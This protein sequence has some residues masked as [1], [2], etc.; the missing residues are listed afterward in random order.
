MLIW[1]LTFLIASIQTLLFL[2]KKK[3]NQPLLFQYC[4]ELVLTI[5]CRTKIT[6]LFNELN[7]NYFC[8]KHTNQQQ[9]VCMPHLRNVCMPLTWVPTAYLGL[10]DQ[11]INPHHS[12]SSLN[13]QPFQVLVENGGCKRQAPAARSEQYSLS[14]SLIVQ[15]HSNTIGLVS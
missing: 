8:R 14:L 4:I 15:I 5:K 11:I 1:S 7:K 3:K 2:K 9:N 10:I 13:S 12:H 6:D